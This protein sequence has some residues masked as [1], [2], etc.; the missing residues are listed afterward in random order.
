MSFGQLSKIFGH[1]KLGLFVMLL[2]DKTHSGYKSLI[3]DVM[4]TPSRSGVG[5]PV[6]NR[7]AINVLDYSQTLG[8][9]P[10]V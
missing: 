10:S 5:V 9:T 4:C 8:S 6:E 3:K 2:S 1:L 7:L